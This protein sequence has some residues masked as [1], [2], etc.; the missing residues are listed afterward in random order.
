M[1]IHA[2]IHIEDVFAD[3]PLQAMTRRIASVLVRIAIRTTIANDCMT[4]RP[5]I[6][7]ISTGTALIYMIRGVLLS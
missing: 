3:I 7:E 6:C 1:K 5:L 2:D 4:V